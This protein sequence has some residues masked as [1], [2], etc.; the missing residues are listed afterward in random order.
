M[1]PLKKRASE[2]PLPQLLRR[3]PT[4]STRALVLML[5]RAGDC[6][7]GR[8]NH[9]V[10]TRPPNTDVVVLF[11]DHGHQ[12]VDSLR[13]ALSREAAAT[14]KKAIHDPAPVHLHFVPYRL[15]ECQR[16]LAQLGYHEKPLRR[17]SPGKSKFSK[18]ALFA[19][20]ARQAYEELWTIE[21]DV[22]VPC[23]WEQLLALWPP[24]LPPSASPSA[25]AFAPTASP[26]T[27]RLVT[28]RCE[29]VKPSWQWMRPRMC[30]FCHLNGP[31]E[32]AHEHCL[33]SL[34]AITRG[35]IVETDALLRRGAT[36]GHHEVFLPAL[37]RNMSAAGRP[38]EVRQIVPDDAG[39]TAG[40]LWYDATSWVPSGMQAAMR[41]AARLEREAMA[42]S[43]RH[44]LFEA[45]YCGQARPT[46]FHPI[47]CGSER[48]ARAPLN[49][50]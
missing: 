10:R 3:I 17:F 14:A 46:V 4:Q 7:L 37:C 31:G 49:R 29:V 48:S 23:S 24:L 25:A 6:E 2:V 21:A 16:A 26:R 50:T 30:T 38:C 40:L 34:A 9:L 5:H 19:L 44:E 15:D 43:H 8:L 32:P 33:L 12:F 36:F 27:E 1:D 22:L 11:D 39:R 13:H 28:S 18:V 45:S 35:L 41:R 47:K 20:G 42:Q